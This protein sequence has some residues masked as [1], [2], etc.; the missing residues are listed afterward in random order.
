MSIK[1]DPASLPKLKQPK[2][3]KLGSAAPISQKDLV[4][5]PEIPAES[6]KDPKKVAEQLKNPDDKKL[7]QEFLTITGLG[8]WDIKKTDD[9]SLYHIHTNGHR[10][11]DE[12]MPLAHIIAR[13]GPVRHLESKGFRLVQAPKPAPAP[14]Q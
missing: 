1:T 3:K 7:A 13:H 11:T 4:S 12:P 5:L 14:K 10:I 6:K 9:Q 8:Q 2:M